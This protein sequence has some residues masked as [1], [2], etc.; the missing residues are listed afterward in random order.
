MRLMSSTC[1]VFVTNLYYFVTCNI[2]FI[3]IVFYYY[4]TDTSNLC[5]CFPHV[6]QCSTYVLIMF[7]QTNHRETYKY[8]GANR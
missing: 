3:F 8:L 4:L 7:G 1:G 2:Y 5:G 6:C